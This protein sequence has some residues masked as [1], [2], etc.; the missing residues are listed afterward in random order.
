[1]PH[2][3]DEA[4]MNHASIDMSQEKVSSAANYSEKEG[5]NTGEMHAPQYPS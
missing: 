4:G 5:R 3:S 2:S 1:M